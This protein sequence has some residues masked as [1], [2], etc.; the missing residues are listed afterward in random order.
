MRHAGRHGHALALPQH[1]LAAVDDEPHRALDHLVALGLLR[2]DVGLGDEAA[3]AADDVELDE[4]PAGVLTGLPDLDDG[5]QPGHLECGHGAYALL[6]AR[7]DHRLGAGLRRSARR[8]RSGRYQFQSPEQLHRRRDED[9]A[10]DVASRRIAADSPIPNSCR[11]TKLPAE[12][13]ANAAIM[14]I[15]AAVMMRPVCSSP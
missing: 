1:V 5:A 2:V 8:T 10:H 9:R 12:K 6:V 14:M 15:A 3:R 13:P 7:S 11:P 4:L